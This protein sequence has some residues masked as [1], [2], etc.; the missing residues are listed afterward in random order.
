M[1]LLKNGTEA[2]KEKTRKEKNL[3]FELKENAA[4]GLGAL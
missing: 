4:G 1:T 2:W 3:H